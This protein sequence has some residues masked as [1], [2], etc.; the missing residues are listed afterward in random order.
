[1]K[2]LNRDLPIH[3][4][5]TGAILLLVLIGYVLGIKP[6]LNTRKQIADYKD[7]NRQLVSQTSGFEKANARLSQEIRELESEL[8]SAYPLRFEDSLYG[9]HEPILKLVSLLLSK[10]Q[11]EL[12]N[13]KEQS[14]TNEAIEVEIQSKGAYAS[15]I[16]LM[17]DLRQLE[18][19]VRILKWNMN[20]LDDFGKNFGSTCVLRFVPA[21]KQPS[22]LSKLVGKNVSGPKSK[23]VTAN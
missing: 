14:N 22:S 4:A 21:A 1:M 5:G 18:K 6:I 10:R 23:Q 13:F 11:L 12:V 16:G 7:K 9:D 17:H 19:P 2:S 8:H 20:P 15:V 3:L